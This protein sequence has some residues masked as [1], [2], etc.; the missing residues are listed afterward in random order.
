VAEF[1]YPHGPVSAGDCLLCHDPHQSD[2]KALLVTEGDALSA[3]C[4]LDAQACSKAKSV[5]AVL[6]AGG[7]SHA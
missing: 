5:H 2:R 4:H 1:K 3:S 7:T 6:E